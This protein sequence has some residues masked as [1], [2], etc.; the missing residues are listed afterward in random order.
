MINRTRLTPIF[1]KST[2]K[3][4]L[5]AH[6][7]DVTAHP[8]PS[9][10]DLPTTIGKPAYRALIAAGYTRLDHLTNVS[11]AELLKLHG[12]GSKALGLLRHLL[13]AKGQSFAVQPPHEEKG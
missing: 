6:E 2:A 11:E 7:S 5:M 10:S 8:G 3:E 13:A 9:E 12:V 4:H 1:R